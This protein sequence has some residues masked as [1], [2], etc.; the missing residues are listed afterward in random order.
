MKRFL[1]FVCALA[2]VCVA[3]GCSDKSGKS[4]STKSGSTAQTDNNGPNM[5]ADSQGKV[6]APEQDQESKANNPETPVTEP[7]EA[8]V[9]EPKE[10]SGH[11]T[12]KS[13]G[14][15]TQRNSG[16]RT[17]RSSGD[18]TQR[19]PGPGQTR[20]S[21]CPRRKSTGQSRI[22]SESH[23]QTLGKSKTPSGFPTKPLGVFALIASFF[24]AFN[25]TRGLTAP[26]RLLSQRL[27]GDASQRF[28]VDDFL[29]DQ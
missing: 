3:V 2:I 13:S 1:G 18:R 29:V 14:H 20:K 12:Q 9:T 5:N 19:S 10:A 22:V 6:K 23:P 26:A 27:R 16:H 17:Q 28:G 21:R 7:K 24:E 4:E 25:T 8:P 11:R 15:R